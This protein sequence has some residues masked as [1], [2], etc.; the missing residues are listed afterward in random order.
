MCR[1]AAT[2]IFVLMLCATMPVSAGEIYKWT[3]ENGKVHFS[4]YPPEQGEADSVDLKINSYSSVSYQSAVASRDGVV[5]YTTSWCG[6][7]KKAKAYFKQK[8]IAYTEFDIEKDAS[9]KRDYDRLEATGV[10]VILY[11]GERMNGFSVKGFERI[12]SA[13]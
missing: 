6:Y 11:G 10:P 7:C 5:I 3:D 4:E 2:S 1:T 12:Y 9:G 8:N 13:K